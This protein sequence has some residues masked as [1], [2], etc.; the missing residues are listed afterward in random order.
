MDIDKPTVATQSFIPDTIEGTQ[1]EAFAEF[2]DKGYKIPLIEVKEKPHIP[3]G[4]L[5]YGGD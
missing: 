5:E 3:E 1:I 4:Q 2:A